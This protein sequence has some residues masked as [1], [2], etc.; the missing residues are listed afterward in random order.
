M[1]TKVLNKGSKKLHLVSKM[2]YEQQ[3][4]LAGQL[5]C[6]V[7]EVGRGCLAGPVVAAAVI[8][9]IGAWIEGVRDSKQMS[10]EEL[11][12]TAQK[13]LQVCF[14]GLGICDNYLIDNCNIREATSMAMRQAIGNLFAIC[15]KRPAKILVDAMPLGQYFQP[16]LE[17][18][19]APKGE[20]WSYSIAAASI[21]AKV[22]R[23]QMMVN[24]QSVFS[25]WDFSQHKGYGTTAHQQALQE[26]GTT[27]IHRQTFLRKFN[28]NQ[29]GERQCQLFI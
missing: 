1:V 15:P 10:S 5:V 9:P 29:D 26:L 16:E 20:D 8:L 11:T 23:D 4:W 7:D 13:L 24:Y 3:A 21:I 19:S 22:K 27:L 17:V 25:S 14:W 6:G 12:L 18:V 28:Q 2:D